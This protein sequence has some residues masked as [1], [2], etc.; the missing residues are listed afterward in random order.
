MEALFGCHVCLTLGG[1]LRKFG[2]EER[3]GELHLEWDGCVTGPV[4]IHVERDESE[5]GDVVAYVPAGVEAF[6]GVL[7]GGLFI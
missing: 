3:E 2:K 7:L 6:V 5:H 4:V 1:G